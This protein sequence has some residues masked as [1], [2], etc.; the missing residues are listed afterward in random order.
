MTWLTTATGSL[1]SFDGRVALASAVVALKARK[2]GTQ[3]TGYKLNAP[4]I[5][6][7]DKRVQGQAAYVFILRDPRDIWR[8]HIENDFGRTAEAV[9][10]TWTGYLR[11]FERFAERHPERTHLVR[12]EDLVASPTERL[13]ELCAA[14]GLPGA[15]SMD[16]FDRSKA[17]VLAAATPTRRTC[18]R[19][20][21]PPASAGSARSSARPD[22]EAIESTCLR[23]W[24]PTATSRSPRPGSGSAPRS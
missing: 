20:S 4:K 2:E 8:S 23:G 7:F 24:Q 5:G 1:D 15:S 16:R 13:D 9:A 6:A 3:V 18:R 17:S 14:I 11:A 19:T 12:Y 10:D 21:S 22:L